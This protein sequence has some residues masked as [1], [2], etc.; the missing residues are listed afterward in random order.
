MTL[1]ITGGTGFVGRSVI[2]MA[3]EASVSLRALTRRPQETRKGVEWV[4]GALD[5][6]AALAR[7]AR[8]TAAVIHIA[9]L[10]NA[11]DA[12]QFHQANVIGTENVLRVCREEGV[13]RL[14]FVSS[15]S[16]REPALSAY[17]HSKADAEAAVKGSDLDWT[18][19]RPPAVYGPRDTDMLDLFRAAKL[20]VVPLP[21]QGRT[22]IIH[23]E[24]LARLLIILAAE[25]D[26]TIGRTYEPD[27]GKSEG[28]AH[29]E[30]AGLIG[31]AMGRRVLAPHLP[32]GLLMGAA[33]VDRFIRGDKAK[34]T[35]DR[36]GYMAHP[37]WVCDPAKVVSGNI[38]RPYIPGA[39]GLT[40]TAAWYREQG[41]L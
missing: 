5:D 22:S 7:L 14:V 37:D 16:A 25:D 13:R 32:K 6:E 31:D 20:G 26:R 39:K 21:P 17:G 3:G 4:E 23:V 12:A 28:Y 9:G 41:W 19:V 38:W 15:L 35:P 1:A 24:D 40:A 29:R 10:T 18:I 11:P 36:A 34:L 2:D 8:D 27:D 30:L 33:R